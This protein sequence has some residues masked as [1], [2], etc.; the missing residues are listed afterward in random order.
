[1]DLSGHMIPRNSLVDHF[2]GRTKKSSSFRCKMSHHTMKNPHPQLKGGISQLHGCVISEGYIVYH[3]SDT[4][5]Y[6]IVGRYPMIY[7]HKND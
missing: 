7:H 5:K 4:P 6:P 1:M 2:L 3:M